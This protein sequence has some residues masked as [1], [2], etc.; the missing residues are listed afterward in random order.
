MVKIDVSKLRELKREMPG[1]F[2]DAL[3]AAA[4]EIATDIKLSF[5]TSP[6]GQT[7]KRG[8]VTHVASQPGY[9]PNVDI[10][11]LKNSIRAIRGNHQFEHYI[12]DGVQYGIFLELGTERMKARPFFTPVMENW[13]NRK[14]ANFLSDFGLL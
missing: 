5:N 7:Y 14:F 8:N 11:T 2:D 4:E 10:G 9:P 6:A 1:R 13:R 12:V 3:R